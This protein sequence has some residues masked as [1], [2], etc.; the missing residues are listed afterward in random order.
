[1]YRLHGH[2]SDAVCRGA[3]RPSGS[4]AAGVPAQRPVIAITRSTQ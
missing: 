4:R 2:P 3:V 1:M